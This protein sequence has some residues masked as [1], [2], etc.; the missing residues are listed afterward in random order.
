MK[1]AVVGTNF[2]YV[3]IA[4]REL[5]SFSD[6][7]K[8]EIYAC[9]ENIGILYGAIVSTCNRSEIY[10]LYEKEEQLC[11]M[12]EL[13]LD[14]FHMK[15]KN[16]KIFHK[17]ETEALT[18][19][20]EVCAGLQS[21]VV[22]EDQILGQMAESIQFAKEQGKCNKV[23]HKLF[24]EGI[25]CAKAIHRD[26][27]ISEHP[28]SIAY[29]GILQ[30][31]AHGGIEGKKV[32][33]IGAGNMA[34]LAMQ[35]VFEHHPLKVYNVNR[36]IKNAMRLQEKFKDIQI[37]SFDKR[38]EILEECDV[39]IC[40]TSCPHVLICKEKLKTRRK[41]LLCLDLASPRD[42]DEQLK[43]HP[44]ITLF[45]IDSLQEIACANVKKREELAEASRH[46]IIQSVQD[47]EKWMASVPMDKTIAGLQER[48]DE[49]IQS[50][51]DLLER[52]LE[53]TKREKY[54]L[55]K[56]LHASMYRL[57]KEPIRT[58]KQI[59]VDKQEQYKEMV[60]KLFEMEDAG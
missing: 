60:E 58:L 6:T 9:M 55:Y 31:M 29:I 36:S 23:L 15:D 22:G 1:F 33:V 40:A 50:T 16:L 24:Q 45:D 4:Q 49:V 12:K 59:E 17:Q 7:K 8:L 2:Q 14:F 27:K 37:I 18:Y 28:L 56:T 51:Y 34:S 20:F 3:P 43:Y 13:Y 35:Y 26:F 46:H 54:I 42:I 38:Y 19:M 32:M 30:L 10:F 44:D 47:C 21:L 39:L 57:M 41:P 52:K 5:V 53:L 25:R 48:C 11:K